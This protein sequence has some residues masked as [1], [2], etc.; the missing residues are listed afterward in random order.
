MARKKITWIFL[1]LGLMNPVFSNS[2]KYYFT[3]IS[4][5]EGLSQSNVKSICQDSM[6]F[7]W[8]GTRNKLNRYDGVSMKVFDVVDKQQNKTNNN[9]G[10]LLEDSE[11]KL[12]VG[13]DNG[14]FIFDPVYEIFRFFDLETEEG[15][16]ITNWVSDIKMDADGN[17]WIVI[18]GQGLFL[19]TKTGKQLEY[20]AIGSYQEPNQGNPQCMYIGTNGSVWIGTNGAGV[21]LYNSDN[22]MF[23]NY[24]G[25]ANG[26]N[27][28]RGQNIYTISE[29]GDELVIGIHEGKLLKLHK[30]KNI[31]TEF[32]S[33]EVN[34]K[35]IRCIVTIGD[36]LWVGT[37][38]GLFIVDELNNSTTHIT[39]SLLNHYS[40]STNVFE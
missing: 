4:V 25:D 11:R 9:I 26:R 36:Q 35:I 21:Y 20:F 33:E 27:T 7:M 40:I 23:I 12:W 16:R 39:E 2:S 10:A 13:T 34:Y 15:I 37:Q 29:Y 3:K 32:I 38:Y 6:G 5:S 1:L 28:L 30:R 24:M 17:I 22:Q 31:L 8:F 19:Y 18:P 14:I